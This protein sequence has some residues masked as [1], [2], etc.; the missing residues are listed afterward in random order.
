MKNRFILDRDMFGEAGAAHLSPAQMLIGSLV[1]RT[2][3]HRFLICH[4]SPGVL[5]VE[6]VCP[7]SHH[8]HAQDL[9]DDIVEI[10]GPKGDAALMEQALSSLRGP[11]FKDAHKFDDV[12]AL[13]RK[14][15]FQEGSKFG[16]TVPSGLCARLED[17]VRTARSVAAL[18]HCRG[19]PFD[20]DQADLDIFRRFILHELR[21]KFDEELEAARKD[22]RD[23]EIAVSSLDGLLSAIM[24]TPVPTG[25]A[26]EISAAVRCV[27]I[28]R[29]LTG[30]SWAAIQENLARQTVI[31][32]EA[33]KAALKAKEAP[34]AAPTPA[35]ASPMKL[36]VG[37]RFRIQNHKLMKD[38]ICVVDGIEACV[39][40]GKRSMT[41]V[42]GHMESYP[43]SVFSFPISTLIDAGFEVL[44]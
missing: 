29:R 21:E 7:E 25:D 24:N 15:V 28:K 22:E 40:D 14:S 36:K 13:A 33:R 20:P 30:N 34:V 35:P 42:D 44:S 2:V 6:V 32:E 23:F 38:A 9:A 5:R 11:R 27:K 43:D 4:V 3:D 10:S 37:S 12:L 31:A 18:S 1:T 26:S 41:I 19:M 17:A 39:R 16:P 8:R